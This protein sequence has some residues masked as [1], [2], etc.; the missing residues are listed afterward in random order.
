MY[1]FKEKFLE[2]M[3]LEILSIKTLVYK[4]FVC[5]Y[6]LPIQIQYGGT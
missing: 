2:I 1:L 4:N 6:S 3:K 5:M